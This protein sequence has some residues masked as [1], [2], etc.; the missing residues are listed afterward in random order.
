MLLSFN[1]ALTAF[2]SAFP[3]SWLGLMSGEMAY[4]YPVILFTL[5]EI[6]E[7]FKLFFHSVKCH[8]ALRCVFFKK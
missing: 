7:Q 4:R 8:N 5:F 3:R 6:L 1:S 2:Y